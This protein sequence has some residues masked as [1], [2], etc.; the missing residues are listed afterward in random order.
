[1]REP[2]EIAAGIAIFGALVYLGLVYLPPL[3]WAVVFGIMGLLAL[4]AF[5]GL[6]WLWRS[7]SRAIEKMQAFH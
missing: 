3:G 2:L 6:A 1:M 4:V 7:V 5:G